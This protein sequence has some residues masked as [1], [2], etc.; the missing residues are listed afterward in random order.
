[1]TSHLNEIITWVFIIIPLIVFVYGCNTLIKVSIKKGGGVYLKILDKYTKT[2]GEK[3]TDKTLFSAADFFS[4]DSL[5]T[6]LGINLSHLKALS[7]ALVGLGILG[8]FVGLAFALIG[9]DFSFDNQEIAMTTIETLIGGMKSAFWSSVVGMFLSLVY[10]LLLRRKIYHI[11]LELEKIIDEL[12][13]QYLITE[14]QLLADQNEALQQMGNNIGQNIGQQMVTQLQVSMATIIEGVSKAMEEN[15]LE[16][17]RCLQTSAEKIEKTS[18]HLNIV[19]NQFRESSLSISQSI[20]RISNTINDISA[21]TELLSQEYQKFIESI[22][23]IGDSALQLNAAIDNTKEAISYFRGTFSN[24]EKVV[25]KQKDMQQGYISLS[26]KQAAQ[27]N[28]LS[29]QQKEIFN[30][31]SKLQ[32]SILNLHNSIAAVSDIKGDVKTIFDTINKGLQEHVNLLHNQTTGII[33][34]YTSEFTKAAQSINNTVGN[35]KGTV[36]DSANIM[37]QSVSKSATQI[38]ESVNLVLSAKK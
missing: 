34:M 33:S 24:I 15:L 2:V 28:T 23:E 37:L 14:L 12:D 36:E 26:E 29:E 1:M 16:A 8:T 35:L 31:I 17:S 27:I 38:E 7:S 6:A 25:E 4:V 10:G 11:E 20:S 32:D 21:G 3:I 5:C 13:N 19:S 18:D 30:S 22:G 9:V